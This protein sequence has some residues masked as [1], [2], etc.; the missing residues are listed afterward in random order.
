MNSQL[1][2]IA[3]QTAAGALAVEKG[4]WGGVNEQSLIK[5]SNINCCW[6]LSS[7]EEEVNEQSLI[8]Y[9]NI[10]CCWGLSSGEGE[11]NEQS[12]IKYSN[13]NCCWGLSSGEGGGGGE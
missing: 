12:V 3:I 1:S 10:N 4:G 6:G 13:T 11:V 8:K 2:S 7:G 9:S 5:Y